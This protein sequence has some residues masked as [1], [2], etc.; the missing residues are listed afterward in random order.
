VAVLVPDDLH[1]RYAGWRWEL[2][3]RLMPQAPT[4]RLVRASESR[5]LK[6]T[7]VDW[8]PRLPDE[9]M[10]LRWASEHLPVPAMIEYGSDGDANWLMTQALPGLDATAHPWFAADP[11]RLAVALGEGLRRLHDTAPVDDCPYD[12]GVWTA[13]AHVQSRVDS[14]LVDPVRDLHEEHAHFTAESA[15][16]ELRRT[17]PAT[18]DLVVC[19]GDYCLPNVLLDGDRVTGY[20]DVGELGVADRWWDV[21]VGAWSCAWNLGAG[22]EDHFYRGYG[23][24][25]DHDRIAWYR[26]LYDL[27][28]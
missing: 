21:A 1:D 24:A 2:A 19:H 16:A 28:S 18:E 9:A 12:F 11:A 4:Y 25:P 5:Y 3:Y 6:I 26:L 7:P 13:L 22:F 17:V 15:L 10:K 27:V 23:I 20:L 8:Y 14:G